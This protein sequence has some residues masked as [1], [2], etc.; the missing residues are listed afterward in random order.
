MM[1]IRRFA[2]LPIFLILTLSLGCNQTVKTGLTQTSTGATS[3]DAVA[4]LVP[5]Q[6][7]QGENEDTRR[8]LEE[9]LDYHVGNYGLA[10]STS[11]CN[12]GNFEISDGI[13]YLDIV[14]SDVNC[15]DVEVKSTCFDL[16]VQVTVGLISQEDADKIN[17]YEETNSRS[18]FAEAVRREVNDKFGVTDSF[19][20]F[21]NGIHLTFRDLHAADLADEQQM[22]LINSAAD[23]VR[24]FNE[25]NIG[26]NFTINNIKTKTNGVYDAKDRVNIYYLELNLNYYGDDKNGAMAQLKSSL[27][28]DDVVKLENLEIKIDA[29]IQ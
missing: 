22:Y 4:L 24:E 1:R 9:I 7:V 8:K 15:T 6:V 13:M 12:I 26:Q 10:D 19:I 25:A 23:T 18:N 28:D 27:L 20:T 5:T 17:C 3:P 16:D 29:G 2:P 11:A 14:S 21:E